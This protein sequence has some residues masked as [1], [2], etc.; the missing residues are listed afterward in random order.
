MNKINFGMIALMAMMLLGCGKKFWEIPQ[1]EISNKD[2][3]ATRSDRQRKLVLESETLTKEVSLGRLEASSVI[4]ITLMG[5]KTTPQFTDIMDQVYQSSWTKRYC[6][7]DNCKTC[8]RFIECFDEELSGPCTHRYREQTEYNTTE[9]I[10]DKSLSD[11]SLKIRIG[12]KLYS[13]GDI[14]ENQK[15][16]IVTRLQ[17]TKEMLT[18]SD[19]VFL[20]VTPEPAQATVQ[21]GFLGLGQCSGLGKTGFKSNGPTSSTQVP[22]QESIEYR[23]SA[24]IEKTIEVKNE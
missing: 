9:L 22:N 24:V 8:T 23:V 15:T 1:E 4:E 13:L 6:V 2:R 5:T 7:S 14:T 17:L 10:F 12:Q 20:T 21:V 19:E 16:T 11:L 18:E 3:Y